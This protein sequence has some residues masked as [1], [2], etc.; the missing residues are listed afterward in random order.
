MNEL[1]G[2]S[3]G[4]RGGAQARGRLK[5][6]FDRLDSLAVVVVHQSGLTDV[7]CI[8]GIHG[9]EGDEPSWYRIKSD[10]VVLHCRASTACSVLVDCVET[11]SL[12]GRRRDVIAEMGIVQVRLGWEDFACGNL[13]PVLHVIGRSKI[14]AQGLRSHLSFGCITQQSMHSIDSASV[15]NGPTTLLMGCRGAGAAEP[16]KDLWKQRRGG[17]C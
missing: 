8:K 6:P 2:V 17:G 10:V 5:E 7:A 14:T 12:T 15:T 4:K 1:G 11:V 13:K 16:C 3:G 9:P